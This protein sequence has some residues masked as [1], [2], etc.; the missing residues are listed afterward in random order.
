MII[1]IKGR[2]T[3]MLP[4]LAAHLK[5]NSSDTNLNTG[6]LSKTEEHL[7]SFK[8]RVLMIFWISGYCKQSLYFSQISLH[9]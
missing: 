3:Y 4:V 9:I 8:R 2:K 5:E 1:K 7:L 6:I